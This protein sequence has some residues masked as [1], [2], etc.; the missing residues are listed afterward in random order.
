MRRAWGRWLAR[1]MIWLVGLSTWGAPLVGAVQA[2][3]LLGLESYAR[4]WTHAGEQLVEAAAADPHDHEARLMLGLMQWAGGRLE[5]AHATLDGLLSGLPERYRPHLQVLVGRLL[6][7]LNQVDQAEALSRQVLADHPGLALG[8][9]TL[10]E[11]LLSQGRREEALEPL[12]AAR[13]AGPGVSR[14]YLL[15]GQVLASLGRADEAREVLELGARIDPWSA[16][17]Q[18]ALAQVYEMLALTDRAEH[19]YRRAAQLG[20]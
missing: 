5:A 12:R 14:V 13:A 7:E 18:L 17:L 16:E 10:A 9:L 8:Q 6:L 11:A 4:G 2:S 15:E 1:V 19:A 3:F 20:L